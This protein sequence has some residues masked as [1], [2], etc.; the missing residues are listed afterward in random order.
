MEIKEYN[1]VVIGG[2]AAG[3]MAAGTAAIAGNSV[4]LLEKMEKT[5]R[6]VRITGKGR[7]N[8]TN[9]C[10]DEEFLAKVQNGAGFFTYAYTQWNNKSLIRFMERKGVKLETERGGR[11]FPQSGKAWDIAQAL[12]DWCRE[13]GVT[14]ECNAKVDSV[15]VIAGKVRRVTYYNARGYQ[16]RVETPAVILATGGAS[17]PATGST[18]DG[19][20]IAH[21]V[22]HTIVPIRPSLVP[23]E[24]SYEEAPYM[25]GL[26]LKNVHAD[27]VVDGEVVQSEFGEM[28]FSKRGVEGAIIL[29]M[30][31]QAVDALIEEKRV[32]VVVDLKHAMDHD[33]LRARIERE[34]A[35]QPAT[36]T[37]GELLRKIMPRE[38]VVPMAKA[39]GAHAKHSMG[40]LKEDKITRLV[41]ALKRFVLPISDYRPFEEAIVTAGGVDLAEIDPHIFSTKKTTLPIAASRSSVVSPNASLLQ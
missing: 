22:G 18:G 23:L 8:L 25:A 12:V 29:R 39:C 38:L 35:E 30:S 16:R 27:L 11:V 37:V 10:T 33:E 20:R 2:G 14:I 32:E 36:L 7:C 26:L 3:L 21:E 6:K 31:R 19:Y 24:T 28:F 15:D 9:V 40:E 34:I 41:D 13:E 4:L 1:V 17:Y 5:G